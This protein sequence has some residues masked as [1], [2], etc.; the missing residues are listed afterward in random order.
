MLKNN[1]KLL[2]RSLWRNKSF[3]LLNILGLAVGIAVSLLIFLLIR[4]EL[5]VDT[6]HSKRDRIYRV[7]SVEYYRNGTTDYDGCAPTPLADA[8]RRE[9]PQAEQVAH[10][11]RAGRWPFI[12]PG[13]AGSDEKQMR[14]DNIYFADTPLF[15]IFDIPWLAGNPGTAL[16]ETYTMAISRSVADSWFGHWQD[17]IG[18]TVL[19]GED[20]RPFRVTGVMEDAPPNTDIPLNVVLSYATYR[21]WNE[22]ELAD[23][24]SWD[25]FSTSSQ[26]FFLL[27]KGQSIASM[28]AR[29]P[30]FVATHFTPLYAHSDS[31]D[32]CFFQPLKE[33]H[34]AADLNRFGKPGWSY[35]ELWSMGLIGGFLLV[36]ACINFINLATAQSL[37]RAKEVGV[38]KVLGSNRRQLLAG[39]LGETALLVLLA[40]VLGCILTKMALPALSLMLEKPVV[41]DG[42]WPIVVFLLITGISVTMLAGFYPGVVLSRFNPISAF[43][44]KLNARVAGGLSLRRGLLVMQFTIAQLL[45]IGT[46]V[47]VRQMDF[48]RSRPMGFER[49]AVALVNLPG[50]KDGIMKNAYFQHKALQVQGITSVSLCSSAP[51]TYGN[52][53]SHFTFERH[54]HPEGFELVHRAGDSAYLSLF[55]IALVA[56]RLPYS[57]DTSREEECLFNETVVRML[58]LTPSAVLGKH[59]QVGSQQKQI[60]VVGVVRDFNHSSLREKIAPLAIFSS[61]SRFGTLAVK[62]DPSRMRHAL[63]QLQAAFA[64]TYPGN[65]F[66]AT[67]LE[68]EVADYYHAERIASTLFKL[69]A[70]LAIFISCLGLYGL[71]SFMAVQKTKEVGVRKV[72]GASVL[73]IVYL[74]STEFALVIGIAF[75]IAA[76][77]G[78]YF[79]QHWLSGYHY[80]MRLGWEVFAAAILSSVVIAWVTVG[81]KAVKAALANP[82]KSLR[83][84]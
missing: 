43:K 70:A 20:R 41:L 42:S 35:A 5:S 67:F 49:K 77:V 51:S 9:F 18:K 54:S 33:M 7:V 82:V 36:V 64:E 3:S 4:Y 55:H 81:Y 45:I 25:N 80:H 52:G 29:L 2:V 8:L 40:L 1:L 63:T 44:G 66:D 79:M 48:F 68:E 74:F 72:L 71:V 17:A 37:G 23:P 76:P 53:S 6:W 39:F 47:I 26:C 28:E 75:L 57:S 31:R 11:W 62:L 24:T 34:F 69:F 10:V 12:L 65:F 73:D 60:A 30:Q 14:V 50:S 21:A 84:E 38:R 83:T 78:Y 32:S 13:S 58:G 46:L 19:Q 56:G 16:K 27:R 22:K 15:K 59:L 61:A